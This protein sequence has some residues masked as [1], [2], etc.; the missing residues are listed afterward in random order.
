MPHTIAVANFRELGNTFGAV[1]ELGREFLDRAGK[2]S[3][4]K[5]A[6]QKPRSPAER[7]RQIRVHLSP[8]YHGFKRSASV[9]FNNFSIKYRCGSIRYPLQE[10]ITG[11]R[12]RIIEMIRTDPH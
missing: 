8:M 7:R 1:L 12:Q 3:V 11:A 4:K 6:V 10:R 5:V 9:S 2:S